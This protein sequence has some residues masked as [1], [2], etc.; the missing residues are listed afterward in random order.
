MDLKIAP[1]SVQQETA[2]KL[3]EAIMVGH[4]KPGERLVES[5]LCEQLGVS[6][7][8]LREALRALA[9]EHL[10]VITPNRGPSVARIEWE[11]ASQIYQARALIEGEIAALAARHGNDEDIVAM[12]EALRRFELAV[13]QGD[14]AQRVVATTAFYDAMIAACRNDVLG[15]LI[16]GLLAR[17]NFLRAQTMA[18]P[19]R[20]KHS[21]RELAA[22]FDA[23]EA[24]DARS[25]RAA[26][27]AHVKAAQQEAHEVFHQGQQSA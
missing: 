18:M 26:A 3:R 10:V 5:N 6:R 12:R 27:V 4:F 2:R 19:G 7:P 9:A 23:I 24:R 15:S 11:E 1:V 25:A 8:S 14:A 16:R 20:A 13:K 22:I 17:I 21:Y